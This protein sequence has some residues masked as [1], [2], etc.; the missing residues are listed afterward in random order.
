MRRHASTLHHVAGPVLAQT[1]DIEVHVLASLLWAKSSPLAE[2]QD[3]LA[4]HF[5][6]QPGDWQLGEETGG[7][8]LLSRTTTV[9]SSAP[10]VGEHTIT[11]KQQLQRTGTLYVMRSASSTNIKMINAQHYT[12][13]TQTVLA[14]SADGQSTRVR[15]SWTGEWTAGKKP[16]LLAG[17][18]AADIQTLATSSNLAATLG[19]P[20]EIARRLSTC[21]LLAYL[22]KRAPPRVQ[23]TC[24]VGRRRACTP[25]SASCTRV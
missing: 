1:Y 11:D 8:L 23:A 18:H 17:A 21:S 10:V 6:M 2:E 7:S 5:D 12:T 13:I 24:R 16:K 4:K 22:L 15:A 19:W 3:K 9:K 20:R 14:G 25:H